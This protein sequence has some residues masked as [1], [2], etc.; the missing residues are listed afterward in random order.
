M[1]VLSRTS[2]LAL[3]LALLT[4]VTLAQ[5]AATP[6]QTE[7]ISGM[8][9]FLRDGEFVQITVEQDS[10][11]KR[12]VVSGFISRYA[13]GDS[14]KFL[15]HLFSKA[16][17]EGDRLTF[18]TKTIHGVWFEFDGIVSRGKA[19]ARADEGYFVVKGKL[20]QHTKSGDKVASKS[21]EL[22]M[23]SFPNVDGDEQPR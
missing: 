1:S 6:A 12:P 15:D 19:K 7:D 20:T 13:D 9:S 4:S 2:H 22:E 23:K 8:Y 17:L 5:Q 14:D 18:T 21:R 16:A 3:I 11:G 10:P